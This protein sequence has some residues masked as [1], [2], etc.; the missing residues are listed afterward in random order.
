MSFTIVVNKDLSRWQKIDRIRTV[1]F[2]G[3]TMAALTKEGGQKLDCKILF[4]MNQLVMKNVNYQ[5]YQ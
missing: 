2:A 3:L 5:V 1:A 4:L